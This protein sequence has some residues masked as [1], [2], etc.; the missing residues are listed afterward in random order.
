MEKY[1]IIREGLPS[2]YY[3]DIVF[4]ILSDEIKHAIKYNYILY[5]NL[6]PNPT[7]APKDNTI[8]QFDIED[9]AAL[10]KLIGINF[11]HSKFNL[12]QFNQGLNK[13]LECVRKYYPSNASFNNPL[14]IAKITHAHLE[15]FPDY[16][17]RLVIMQKEAKTFWQSQ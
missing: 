14:S 3:R 4:K 5:K 9:A 7:A 10:A 2:R 6:T 15:E 11:A 12:E 17:G 16:Y 8:P 13:E 1:R